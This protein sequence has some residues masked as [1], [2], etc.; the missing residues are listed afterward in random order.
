LRGGDKIRTSHREP[1]GAPES[2]GNPP[3]ATGSQA[4]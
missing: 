2:K 4:R 3:K 1:E